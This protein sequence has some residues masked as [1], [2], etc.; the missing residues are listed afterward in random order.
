MDRKAVKNI[1]WIL[2]GNSV[3]AFGVNCFVVPHGIIMGGATGI[4]IALN[5]F[6]GMNLSYAV[7]ILNFLLFFFY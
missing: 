3:L 4:G 5:K 6:T 2:L 7:W 1:L